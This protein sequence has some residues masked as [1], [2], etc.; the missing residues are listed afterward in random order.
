VKE[1]C[2]KSCGQADCVMVNFEKRTSGDAQN[3][4]TSVK[5]RSSPAFVS[6]ILYKE[7]PQVD[8]VQYLVNIS[9][10]LN[11]WFGICFIVSCAHLFRYL[12]SKVSTVEIKIE[13]NAN[14][15]TIYWRRY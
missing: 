14:F 7:V 10:V 12:E 13:Q 5:V 15:E 4:N 8:V 2:K 3:R 6:V 1:F 9:S 11:F